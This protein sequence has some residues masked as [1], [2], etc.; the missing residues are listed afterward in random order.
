MKRIR[1]ADQDCKPPG[2]WTMEGFLYVQEKREWLSPGSQRDISITYECM[3]FTSISINMAQILPEL[4]GEILSQQ[5]HNSC[6]LSIPFDVPSNE[7]RDS[8]M[9][10]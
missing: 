8:Q 1:S 3:I 4:C 5:A 9:V 10:D 7:Q 6:R 2:L